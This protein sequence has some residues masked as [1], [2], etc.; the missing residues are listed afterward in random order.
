ML[1][2][3][4]K[5]QR[6]IELFKENGREQ[7]ITESNQWLR[8]N[9]IEKYIEA[10]ETY[11]ISADDHSV[12]MKA[13]ARMSLLRDGNVENPNSITVARDLSSLGYDIEH[14]TNQPVTYK[15]ASDDADGIEETYYKSLSRKGQ[16]KFRGAA[17]CKFN[18][19]CI[20]SG[21]KI[22]SV[23]EA[24]HI[25]P[26]QI[27]QNY[28][29]ENSLLLRVDLHKLFDL[30]LLAIEPA[31]FQIHLHESIKPYYE[32][33]LLERLSLSNQKLLRNA[34]LDRRWSYFTK[35]THP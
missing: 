7:Y 25:I 5:I 31:T 21:C 8:S 24:A 18:S 1:F 13:V 6:E 27:Q 2:A 34:Y 14:I 12:D 30:N 22:A 35:D 23:L 17:L 19:E 29:L 20:L 33:Q 16:S 4:S 3:K 32:D 10:S 9:N 15:I 28:D 26:F 11:F